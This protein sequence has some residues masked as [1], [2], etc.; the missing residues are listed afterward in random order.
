VCV[1]EDGGRVEI[2]VNAISTVICML[3]KSLGTFSFPQAL[4]LNYATYLFHH[5]FVGLSSSSNLSLPI[6]TLI[7]FI[8]HAFYIHSLIFFFLGVTH[9]V[10]T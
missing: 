10:C 5:I 1:F 3:V 2:G 6:P 7:S 8:L 9:N 4:V